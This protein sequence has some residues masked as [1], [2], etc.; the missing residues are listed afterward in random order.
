MCHGA[1]HELNALLQ[2]NTACRH[3]N[4][5][6]CQGGYNDGADEEADCK[7]VKGQCEDIKANVAPKHGVGRAKWSAV[8]IPQ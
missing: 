5:S 3:V 8:P 4:N 1:R 7:L 6:G 2:G